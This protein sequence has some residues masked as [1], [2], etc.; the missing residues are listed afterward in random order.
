MS[1]ITFP[2]MKE[3][4]RNKQLFD[5]SFQSLSLNRQIHL[6]AHLLNFIISNFGD[7]KILLF[8]FILK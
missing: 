3:Y 2:P 7:E 1:Q 5:N 4:P 6:F 8:V